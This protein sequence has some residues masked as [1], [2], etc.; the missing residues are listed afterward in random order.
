MAR[1]K[2]GFPQ[3]PFFGV[4]FDLLPLAGGLIWNLCGRVWIDEA[5]NSLITV[6]C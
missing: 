4:S 5:V 3:M 1:S 6:T 2:D